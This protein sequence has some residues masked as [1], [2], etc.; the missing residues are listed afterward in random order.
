MNIDNP[1]PG[2]DAMFIIVPLIV[3]VGFV[4]VIGALVVRGAQGTAHWLN[5]NQQPVQT[6][7]AAVVSKR[8]HVQG[9]SGYN[10]GARTT[11]TYFATFELPTGERCELKLPGA[12]Y[13]LLAEGDHG[14]VTLQGSRFH[15]WERALR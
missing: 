14:Q 9:Y 7:P 4:F 10:T 8:T 15:T 3:A 5:D 1:F 2:A 11:T 12:A 13:G 6:L